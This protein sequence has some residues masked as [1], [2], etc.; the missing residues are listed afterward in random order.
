MV[1]PLTQIKCPNCQSPIQAEIEILIDAGRD[2]SSKARLLSGSF[3]RIGCPVCGFKGQLTSPL[4]YHDPEKELL[5]TFMPVE[6]SIPKDEQE[7]VIGRAINEVI[8]NLP[9]DKRK[10]YLF[11]PQSVL[12][13]QSLVERILEADGVTKEEI[14]AQR[15]RMRLFEDLLRSPADNLDAFISEHDSE[16]DAS[17]FQL[18]SLTLQATESPQAQQA[19]NLRLERALELS[20]FGKRIQSQ[21]KELKGAVDS[22]SQV[23]KEITREDILGLLV[24]AP[25]D[26]RVVA[27]VNLTRPALDYTFFQLLTV[28][29]EESEKPEAERL[30]A[31][32]DRI[33]ELTSEFDKVQEAR[34]TQAAAVLKSLI[35][36]ED[37][38]QAIIAALPVVDEFF[39]GILQ[40]NVQAAQEREDQT[41]LARL[42]QISQ[43]LQEIIRGSL[44]PGIQ[45]AQQLLDAEDE[46]HAKALLE[47]SPEKIDDQLLGALMSTA[48]KLE[49]AD[50]G[51][52]AERVRSLYRLALGIS[53]KAKMQTDK[54]T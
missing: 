32:R 5:L 39:L 31:L 26:D 2:P 18:A 9:A 24:D 6:L 28:R 50:N 7:R 41:T 49:K 15:S 44:P 37:L 34:A 38:D 42:E 48:E 43:R 17:F 20:T 47:A 10:G 35:E 12:T 33:L 54:N 3:N 51:A 4:V 45:L 40:A 11:Q 14:E 53:M 8:N 22:L 25:N 19:V 46:A 27:L 16:L 1:H 13:I 36:A 23:G 52:D 30:T 21:E 29:I